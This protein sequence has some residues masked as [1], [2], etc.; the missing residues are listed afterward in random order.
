[1]KPG[2][3]LVGCLAAIVSILLSIQFVAARP[4]DSQILAFEA[5][6]IVS[7]PPSGA[8]VVAGSSTIVLWDTISSDLAPLDIIP[9]GFGGSTT[10]DPD[11]YLDRIVLKY[12]PRAV[13][14]YEGDNDIALG[15]TPEY[16]AD[17]MSTILSRISD[18]LPEARVYIISIKPSPARWSVWPLAAEA[19][20]RLADLCSLDA[21]YT[22]IDTA[23]AL[24]GPDGQPIPA[25]FRE[26]GLHLNTV[27]YAAFSAVVR[28]VLIAQQLAPPPPAPPLV[29]RINAAGPAYTDRS[30]NLWSADSG[31]NTGNVVSYSTTTV[32]AGTSD[33]ALY[34]TERWDSSSAPELAYRFTV[35]NGT[36]QIRLHFAE[37]Y[38]GTSGVGK[39]VFDVQ[40]EDLLAI[41][42]LDIFAAV[43][44]R[45]ALVRTVNT[46]VSDGQLN[47]TFL[48]GVE[49]PIVNAIEIVA[50]S[51]TPP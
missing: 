22:F 28:P 51:I 31:F 12:N 17:G 39:R 9:R 43:G 20:R 11:Y 27:G 26:D 33:P 47:I 10:D 2:S 24:L 44:A 34:R 19:N 5:A 36:Y 1:M 38:S 14:I 7:P 4:W 15:R 6:D 21:R 8:I 25:Y 18:R 49:N 42:N 41:D 35:P 30:G 23:A 16:V 3:F 40:V 50:T 45:T 13:V 37:N 46:I 29:L 48:H 32:I